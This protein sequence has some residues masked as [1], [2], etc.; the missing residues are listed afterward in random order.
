MIKGGGHVIRLFP[1]ILTPYAMQQGNSHKKPAGGYN[2]SINIGKLLAP[3]TGEG[4]VSQD[5]DKFMK[6]GVATKK[7]AEQTNFWTD[8]GPSSGF[9]ERMIPGLSNE[10]LTIVC[11]IEDYISAALGAPSGK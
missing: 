4:I 8:G 5:K 10:D 2:H 9:F 1:S 6:T 11:K 3:N 7:I